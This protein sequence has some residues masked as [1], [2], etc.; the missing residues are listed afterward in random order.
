MPPLKDTVARYLESAQQLQSA[1]EFSQTRALAK[2]FLE[3]EGPTLQWYLWLKSW[4][5][6]NYV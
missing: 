4:F 6:D 3:K 1:E 2:A 5:F